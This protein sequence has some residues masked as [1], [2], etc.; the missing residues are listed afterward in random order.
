MRLTT[1]TIKRA[2]GAALAAASFALFVTALA[3]VLAL[4]GCPA[5]QTKPAAAPPRTPPAPAASTPAAASYPYAECVAVMTWLW[6][7]VGD[8]S[9]VEPIEWRDRTAEIG[10]SGGRPPGTVYLDLK[11][12]ARNNVGALQV[13][14]TR[15]VVHGGKVLDTIR[16]KR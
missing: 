13:A 10:A 5:P 11:Y 12:R 9:S 7:N 4:A 3:G 8:P 16:L 1:R 6:D 15:F 14:E 2:A